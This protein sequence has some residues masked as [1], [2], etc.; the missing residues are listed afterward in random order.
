V[1]TPEQY[2]EKAAQYT[3]LARTGNTP[4][5]VREFQAHERSL[6]ML[7]EN[8]Q[9][10]A[11]NDDKLADNLDEMPPV[12]KPSGDSKA[13]LAA[14]Q[15]HI[16]RCLGAALIMQWNTLQTELQRELFDNAGSMGE[17]SDTATL[18]GQIARFLRKHTNGHDEK[19]R[20][21]GQS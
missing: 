11:D 17:L 8:K 10:L 14:E 16:L 20:S 15:E 13:T 18:R 3:E 19:G 21:S 6:T 12:L 4:N 5:E 7:A 2:R 1:F 9:W